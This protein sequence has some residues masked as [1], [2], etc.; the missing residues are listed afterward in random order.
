[1]EC[2][3]RDPAWPRCVFDSAPAAWK[4]EQQVYPDMIDGL[5][6]GKPRVAVVHLCSAHLEGASY[7][8]NAYEV[9]RLV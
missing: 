3:S 5:P 6:A 8:L 2:P 4:A 7:L 9:A 1:M